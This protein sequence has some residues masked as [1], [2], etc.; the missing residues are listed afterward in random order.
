MACR[1]RQRASATSRVMRAACSV[2]AKASWRAACRRRRRRAA[3]SVQ[4]AAC[5]RRRARRYFSRDA[6]EETAACSVQAAAA[7]CSVQRA[8]GVQAAA[9]RRYFRRCCRVYFSAALLPMLPRAGLQALLLA[10]VAEAWRA[11]V[12]ACRLTATGAPT[13]S[14]KGVRSPY[15][16]QTREEEGRG[17]NHKA[18]PSGHLLFSSSAL[19][20]P[21]SS[22]HPL[23]CSER[24][25]PAHPQNSPPSRIRGRKVSA[26][27][28]VRNYPSQ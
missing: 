10:D 16:P 26:R 18:R 3:C 1:R 2:H 21:P 25:S 17:D 19:V 23:R 27:G 5:R 11:S 12:Q 22:N 7:A 24:P 13:D 14:L 20:P 28:G 9:C 15:P 4:A 8:G 6:A